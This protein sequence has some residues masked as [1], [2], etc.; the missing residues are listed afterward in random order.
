M[1]KPTEG[2]SQKDFV[3]RCIPI[4][5][6]E[7]TA[8]DN[9]QAAAICYSIWKKAKG[10]KESTRLCLVRGLEYKEIEGELIVNGLIATSHVDEVGDKV[11]K[12]TLDAWANDIN[13]G[14]PLANKASYHHDRGD[15]KV[16]GRGQEGTAKVMQLPDGEYGLY[17]Q[18]HVNKTWAGYDDLVYELDNKFIDGFS[19]EYC[20]NDG[21]TTHTEW[22]GDKSVRI[23]GPDTE[24]NGWGFASRAINPNAIVMDFD[25]KE[26]LK[27]NTEVLSMEKDKATQEE[28]EKKAQLEKEN[29][30]QLEKEKKE[31]EI[32]ETAADEDEEEESEGDKEDLKEKDEFKE[33]MQYKE[34]KKKKMGEKEF[35]DKVAGIVKDLQVKEKVLQEKAKQ[36][37]EKELPIEVKE[38]KEIFDGKKTIDVKEQFRRASAV[39]DKYGLWEKPTGKAELREFKNFGIINNKL[40]YKSLG[41]TTNQNSDTDYLQSSAELQ[42]V[43]D[44]VIYNALNQATVTWN[45]L[46]KEDNSTKGNNQVQ[47]VLKTAANASAM[48]YTGNGVNTGNVTRLKYQTKFKKVQVGVSVDGDM[49]AASRGGPI[50]D[51]FAKEVEDS[52]MDMLAVVNAA[53]FA[54]V[55]AETAAGCIGFEYITDSAGNTT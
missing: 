43:Y 10:L 12:I 11:P 31:K 42:D 9:K 7:G 13:S 5:M 29:K 48:F 14:L 49:L 38:F 46:R 15:P 35:Q 47:F 26:V 55:G 30:E 18:T 41:M 1:P 8:G 28:K 22:I 20:T 33:F 50:G 34:F 25:F 40:E 16:V 53:L 24:L 27:R 3:S 6:D 32:K 21:K 45:V 19:I 44:P 51:V 52:T 4:V 23:L 2:E 54:E 36:V 37:E 17:V 39:A